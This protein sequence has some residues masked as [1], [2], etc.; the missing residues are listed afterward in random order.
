MT[1]CLHKLIQLSHALEE[2]YLL[3]DRMD[4]LKTNLKD[5]IS[6]DHDPNGKH[7]DSDSLIDHV[8]DK[9]DPTP[10]KLHTQ[11]VVN[12]YRK[13]GIAQEDFPRVKKAL[14]GFELTKKNLEVKDLNKFNSVADLED[15]VAVQKG[16]TVADIKEKEA[17][18]SEKVSNMEPIY[19][20]EH[21]TGFK[22]PDKKTSVAM[23]GPAGKMEKT[24]WCTAA[25]SSNMFNHYIG[26]KYTFHTPENNVLQFHHK[27]GQLMDKDNVPVN[28]NNDHRFSPHKEAIKDFINSTGEAEGHKDIDST[29]IKKVGSNIT[30]EKLAKHANNINSSINSSIN[31]RWM[32]TDNKE[33]I[34][35]HPHTAQ[36][37]ENVLNWSKQKGGPVGNHYDD[38]IE[39]QLSLAQ[40]PSAPAPVL[41]DLHN[42]H[43]GGE[44]E[45]NIN[46]YL[47]QN[48]SVQGDTRE[49]LKKSTPEHFAKRGDLHE[50]EISHM[51]KHGNK[52]TRQNL[53]K[54]N[55]VPLSQEQQKHAYDIEDKG[56]ESSYHR[57]SNISQLLN[58][59]DLH[60][61]IADAAFDEVHKENKHQE[62]Y[63]KLSPEFINN[64]Y[65]HMQPEH[66]Y[67]R[68]SHEG[69][70]QEAIEHIVKS[71]KV[72]PADIKPEHADMAIESG[73]Y[74]SYSI[75]NIK[76]G[77]KH[78]YDKAATDEAET[79]TSAYSLSNIYNHP[80][81]SPQIKEKIGA[82]LAQNT[83]DDE[84]HASTTLK[85]MPINHITAAMV[86]GSNTAKKILA[87]AK[88]VQKS[89]FDEMV[90]N[91]ALHG[92]IVNSKSA[93]PSILSQLANSPS[94]WIRGKVK[95]HKNTP[96]DVASKIQIEE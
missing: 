24:R 14:K 35:N 77:S 74:K 23:Y 96:P 76:G 60:H 7:R 8:A 72:A 33:S 56:V 68:S 95:T 16:R 64:N 52:E 55:V 86:T 89:H 6:F 38:H 25:N 46:A 69:I 93:P 47:A 20:T 65:K 12:Q 45:N 50:D 62:L 88:N 17:V 79:T 91:P 57:K 94:D 26:G 39:T 73:K 9:V 41:S 37:F 53:Y 34:K 3:E 54:N 2:Q 31:G 1:K 10:Q 61:S 19:Q 58:R 78:N 71:G 43:K 84:E 67:G 85:S 15:H 81:V 13:G 80:K 32:S 48:P 11:W 36:T 29:L 21:G 40:N 4:Y 49:E 75:L 87:S 59:P 27:S 83:V 42:L 92:A 44:H 82:K 51:I 18:N 30:P 90:K 63:E 5:K 28:L 66:V 70:S 22:I